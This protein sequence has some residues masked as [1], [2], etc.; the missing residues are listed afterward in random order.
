[1]FFF[2]QPLPTNNQVFHWTDII[3]KLPSNILKVTNFFV[4]RFNLNHREKYFDCKLFLSLN[5]SDFSF[6]CKK[7][8]RPPPFP[9]K[10]TPFFVATS[11][12]N[13]NPTELSLFENLVGSATLSIFDLH[14]CLSTCSFYGNPTE[15]SAIDRAHFRH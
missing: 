5:I 7:C 2:D 12:K 9:E 6:L 4:K 3:L 15:S 8:T 10:V 11:S 13:W 14:H 1:M